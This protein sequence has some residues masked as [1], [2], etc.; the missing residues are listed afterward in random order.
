M[1]G[2]RITTLSGEN[3]YEGLKIVQNGTLQITNVSGLG[4]A[5]AGTRVE[6]NAVL[7]ISVSG[8][9]SDPGTSSENDARIREKI[10]LAGGELGLDG[11]YIDLRGGVVLQG[12]GV[13]STIRVKDGST[14]VFARSGEVVG[15]GGL[16][17]EGKRYLRLATLLKYEGETIIEKGELRIANNTT[18]PQATNVSV[19]KEGTLRLVGKGNKIQSLSG[20]G[21]IILQHDVSILTSGLS[22]NNDEFRGVIS[23][24]GGFDKVGEGTTTFT[25][26][27]TYIGE[28]NI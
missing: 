27:N 25:G 14:E 28:T 16:I 15:Q 21:S 2:E 3:T 5:D 4:S 13:N 10:A 20:E 17:K 18:L 9:K 1:K 24:K 26:R 11:N 12:D 7:R 6:K 22:G 8:Q 19:K 23:G